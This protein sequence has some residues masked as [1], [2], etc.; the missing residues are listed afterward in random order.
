MFTY[1]L[2]AVSHFMRNLIR[3]ICL[4]IQNQNFEFPSRDKIIKDFLQLIGPLIGV[5]VSKAIRFAFVWTPS[6]GEGVCENHENLVI[7]RWIK[8]MAE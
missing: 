2:R 5:V 3:D 8:F 7:G 4:E 6:L 1:L